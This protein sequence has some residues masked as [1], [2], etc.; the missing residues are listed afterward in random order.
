M[1]PSA[2]LTTRRARRKPPRF[3]GSPLAQNP[4]AADRSVVTHRTQAGASLDEASGRVDEQ[5]LAGHVS[6]H[7]RGVRRGE[8]CRGHL[9]L[10]HPARAASFRSHGDRRRE[11]LLCDGKRAGCSVGRPTAWREHF[12]L[13]WTLLA[14]LA[15]TATV[16]L[17]GGL[18][19]PLLF[20]ILLPVAYTGPDIPSGRH[21]GVHERS[22]W[23]NC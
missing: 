16:W 23:P 10:Q 12:S 5:L 6:G 22:R 7:V 20:M 15:L 3:A 9:R 18:G 13:V 1:R 17:D 4:G 2:R 8:R 14:G 21:C 11:C 19:S